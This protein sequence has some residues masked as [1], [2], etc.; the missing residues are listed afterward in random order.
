MAARDKTRVYEYSA[1]EPAVVED[2]CPA[3]STYTTP[4]S[5]IANA[6]ECEY[7]VYGTFRDSFDGL[8]VGRDY[9]G[10]HLYVP[11]AN[12][13]VVRITTRTLTREETT[14]YRNGDMP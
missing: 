9:A 1:E 2:T 5:S 7:M 11:C 8:D 4:T 13:Q 12:G 6:V 3:L 14:K 10:T